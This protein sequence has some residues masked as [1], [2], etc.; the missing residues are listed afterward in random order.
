MVD[1]DATALRRLYPA[2]LQLPAEGLA[3]LVSSARAVSLPAGA[4]LFAEHDPCHGFP[5]LLEGS[6]RVT[7]GAPSGRELPLYRVKPGETCIITSGCLLGGTAYNAR[8][9]AATPVR[10]LLVPRAEFLRLLAL[11]AFREFVF[12]LFAERIAGLM[13]LVEEVAFRRLDQRLAGQLLGHGAT[14]RATHQEL[15][16]ELGTVREMT[17]RLLKGFEAQGLVRLGRERIE[18]LDAAGLR[19]LAGPG[20]L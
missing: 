3:A 5:L 20:A 6:V 11:P 7:K 2:L 19:A 17:S 4:T 15:A 9:T 14:I 12:R 1:D 8:G 10:L 16:D 13:Q 18:I